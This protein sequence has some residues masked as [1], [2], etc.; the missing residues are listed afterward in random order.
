[1]ALLAKLRVASE[2]LFRDLASTNTLT[3][4]YSFPEEPTVENVIAT[5]SKAIEWH[6]ECE[7]RCAYGTYPMIVDTCV[8]ISMAKLTTNQIHELC[9]LLNRLYHEA[10]GKWG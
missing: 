7:E 9:V 6:T 4:P 1:M 2:E 8:W 3:G 10:L 5:L